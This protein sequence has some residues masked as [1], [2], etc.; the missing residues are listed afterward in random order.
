MRILDSII[1][2]RGS[3]YAVSG[4]PC[5]SEEEAKAFFKELCRKKKF[6]VVV[7]GLPSGHPISR[8]V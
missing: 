7:T 5:A 8:I 3:K 1:S 2:D 6:A 4:R